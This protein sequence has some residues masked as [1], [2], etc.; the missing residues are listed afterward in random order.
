MNMDQSGGTTLCRRICVDRETTILVASRMM[1]S[2][3]AEALIVTDCV[4]HQLVP[5]GIVSARDIV[6]RIIAAELSPSVLTAGDITW[7]ETPGP[8]THAVCESLRS[9]LSSG[10]KVLPVLDCDGGLTGVVSLDELLGAI[11]N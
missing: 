10:N 1:R 6:T 8:M 7:P 5:V 4:E 2:F 3:E 9:S 11:A